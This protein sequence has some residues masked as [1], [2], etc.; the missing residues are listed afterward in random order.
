[1]SWPVNISIMVS[2]FFRQI[3]IQ[4]KSSLLELC[5]ERALTI[6]P[7]PADGLCLL[8]AVKTILNEDKKLCTTIA[9]IVKK[10]KCEVTVHLQDYLPFFDNKL[11]IVFNELD[12]YLDE[13]KYN[14]DTAD[15]CIS[16]LCN[17]FSLHIVIFEESH[18]NPRQ[19]Q[20]NTYI[21]ELNHP[22]SRSPALFTINLLRSGAPGFEHY[23]AM[24]QTK[25]IDINR[26]RKASQLSI[27]DMF[28]TKNL[29]KSSHAAAAVSDRTVT[30]AVD[31]AAATVTY[32]TAWQIEKFDTKQSKSSPLIS[33]RPCCSGPSSSQSHVHSFQS[34]VVVELNGSKLSQL[35][36]DLPMDVPQTY[37]LLDAQTIQFDGHNSP[38]QD[39]NSTTSMNS[40]ITQLQYGADAADSN[41]I[42]QPNQPRNI[43]FPVKHYGKK[44]RPLHFRK[45]WFDEWKWLNWDSNKS[46]VLC[47]P[48]HLANKLN[49]K[50]LTHNSDPAFSKR[51]Y[52][53]WKDATGDFTKHESCA[54]HRESVTRLIHL[55]KGESVIAKIDSQKQK[56]QKEARVALIKVVEVL[57]LLA[58]QGLAVRGHTD[59]ESNFVQLLSLVKKD[60]Q[61][62]DS[63]LSRGDRKN[64]WLSHDI[65][66]EFLTLMAH[67]VLRRIVS[68]ISQSKYFGIIADETTDTS[69]KQQLSVCIRWVDSEYQIHEDFIGIYE[70]STAAN[71]ENLAN[72]ILDVLLRLGLDV[73][74]MRG[75]CYD[76]ASVMSGQI[77][78][79]ASRINSIEPK[80]LYVHCTMHSLNLAVREATRCVSIL[81][82][83]LDLTR[84]TI[85]FVHASPKRTR[86][87]DDLKKEESFKESRSHMS[88]RPLCPTRFTVRYNS[89]V[90][91]EQNLMVVISALEEVS[92]TSRDDSGVKASGLL[93]RLQSYDT[94]FGLNVAI[95]LFGLTDA[96]SKLTQS[97]QSTALGSQQAM[98]HTVEMLR[99]MRTDESFDMYY[100]ACIKTADQLG[101]KPPMQRHVRPPR[102]IDEG[103]LPVQLDVKGDYRRKYFEV[104]DA[105]AGAI[106]ERCNQPSLEIYIA[107]EQLLIGATSGHAFNEQQFDEVCNFFG[108]DLDKPLLKLQLTT[109]TKEL[110]KNTK[111]CTVKDVVAVLNTQR[112]FIDLLGEVDKLVRLFLVIP[113]SSATAERSFSTTRRL[114]TYLRSTMTAIR[115]NSTVL[116]HAQREYT[117]GLS[118]ADVVGDF[119]NSN[120][121]RKTTFG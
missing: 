12:L 115:L 60:N 36:S 108:N 103:S 105:A 24:T 94:L 80:A 11:S 72:I 49:I 42:Q 25:A 15:I 107:L 87:L 26:K 32:E 7:V 62:L 110:F 119:V 23:D 117:D 92:S 29:S 106:E 19:S 10:I 28:L 95:P 99:S 4:I 75:Q 21:S 91:L 44:R 85:N 68:N 93:K 17:A 27:K 66:N 113:G 1:M 50:L 45:D 13:G 104:L 112:E 53:N 65:Q 52:S 83:T 59:Q 9:D 69:R 6:I 58:R 30:S 14:S 3:K 74:Q 97:V 116:L 88:L 114:K 35:A 111:C 56:Q 63:W 109:S 120:T 16:A 100:S 96:C 20:K 79:V 101:I 70:V 102:K 22:P 54:A 78:G 46:A 121:L 55:K 84:E 71:S 37:P 39:V 67:T 33:K 90:S 98:K 86:I 34:F 40:P 38:Q 61:I 8:H 43:T 89:L 41:V 18:H 51:G 57:R 48:C 73:H 64:K 47:H 118:E 2:C 81:R 77:S 82:D 76:G 31:A 5:R